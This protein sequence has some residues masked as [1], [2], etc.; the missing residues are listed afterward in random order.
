[1]TI[2]HWIVDIALRSSVPVLFYGQKPYECVLE[3]TFTNA[4]ECFS[5][6]CIGCDVE[7]KHK[8]DCSRALPRRLPHSRAPRL[9]RTQHTIATLLLIFSPSSLFTLIF[10]VHR[11]FLEVKL[12]FFSTF[13][14]INT[15]SAYRFFPNH[16][17]QSFWSGADLIQFWSGTLY[18]DRP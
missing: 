7:N 5:K 2:R 14:R 8:R 15:A 6:C 16:R 4:I 10:N 3:T 13:C 1:M 12:A 11:E 18:N 9:A 17:Y